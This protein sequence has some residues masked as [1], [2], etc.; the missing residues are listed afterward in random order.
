VDLTLVERQESES[1]VVSALYFDTSTI[2]SLY[3]DPQCGALTIRLVGESHVR[4]SLYTFLE[5]ASTPCRERRTGLINLARKLLSGYKLLAMPKEIL[6][7]SL[8]ALQGGSR[9]VD[10]TIGPE[11]GAVSHALYHPDQAAESFYST[12]DGWRKQHQKW[13]DDIH[14]QGRPHVQQ[15]IAGLSKA[16]RDVIT[17]GFAKLVRYLCS[18]RDFVA[19]FTCGTVINQAVE[20]VT[21]ASTYEAMEQLETW[22][23]FWVGMTYG[24]Y[25]RSVRS[26]HFSKRRT[27]GGIDTAQAVYLAAGDAFVSS[28]LRQRDMMRLLVPFG[29]KQRHVWGY[30]ELK[31]WLLDTT[32]GG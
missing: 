2:N 3:D 7:R 14:E 12:V 25:V 21:R 32:N 20:S 5:L 18:R 13:Y 28:D 17:S 9:D 27:P 22:R 8:V 31:Q 24:F 16:D 11:W 19:E 23:F 10:P 30:D 1:F 6:D 26:H 4:L 29:W 15:F